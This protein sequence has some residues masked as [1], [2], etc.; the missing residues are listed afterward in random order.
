MNYA[1]KVRSEIERALADG[2]SVGSVEI[3]AKLCLTLRT[4]QRRLADEGTMFGSI[5]DDVRKGMCKNLL[6][7]ES[8]GAT[9]KALG[10][11]DR[12]TL[13]VAHKRWFGVTPRQ[14]KK[15]LVK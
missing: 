5:L 6:K 13:L 12:S 9:A 10:F 3:A 8:V 14:H 1:A 4:L 11:A 2:C 15:G 7:T